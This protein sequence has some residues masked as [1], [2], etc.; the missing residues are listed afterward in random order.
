LGSFVKGG[1]RNCHGNILQ[2]TIQ[3]IRKETKSFQLVIE[4]EVE[5]ITASP[6]I[7][8]SKNGNLT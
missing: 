5:E 7:G 4:D 2:T 3:V 8:E 6:D 1:H